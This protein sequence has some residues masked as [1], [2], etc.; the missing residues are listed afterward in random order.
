MKNIKKG[1]MIICIIFIVIAISIKSVQIYGAMKIK[2]SM[3]ISKKTSDIN[4]GYNLYEKIPDLVFS[5]ENNKDVSLRDKKGKNLIICFWNSDSYDGC[6]QARAF[7][8]LRETFKKY[9]NT[10][11]ILVDVLNNENETKEKAV[12]YLKENN[13]KFST[14][15]DENGDVF[16]KFN[17]NTIPTT[18]VVNKEG[19]LLKKHEGIIY[20]N[21]LLEGY[22]ENAVNGSNAATEK[23]IKE[24]LTNSN[25]GINAQYGDKKRKHIKRIRRNNA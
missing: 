6:E 1:L 3:N 15:F 22:I 18:I 2:N 12:Q 24:N 4:T 23:F 8:V 25:G 17:L 21:G 10:E 14:L 9:E 13:I 20:D 16:N 19:V 11:C 7:Y 5:D